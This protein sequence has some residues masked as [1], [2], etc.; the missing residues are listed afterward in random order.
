MARTT[1]YPIS[2]I[3]Q[4]ISHNIITDKGVLPGESIDSLKG[5]FEEELKKRN[6]VFKETWC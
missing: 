5:V 2:I 4:L 1:A 3:G 6:I